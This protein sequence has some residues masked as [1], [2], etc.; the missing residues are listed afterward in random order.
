MARGFGITA[1]KATIMS[2]T[3]TQLGYDL[4]AVFNVDYETA[5]QKLQSAIAG[6]PRPMREWV[7]TYPKPP[8]KW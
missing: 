7:L 4:A 5:M 6:Q 1:E 3:L 2:K 8:S